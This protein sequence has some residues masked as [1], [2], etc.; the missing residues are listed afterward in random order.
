M[1]IFKFS[2]M[3]ECIYCWEQLKSN[4]SL[5]VGPCQPN[6]PVDVT[7][8][9]GWTMG[10]GSFLYFLPFTGHTQLISHYIVKLH[11]QV[12]IQIQRFYPSLHIHCLHHIILS[13][14]RSRSREHGRIIFILFTFHFFHSLHNIILSSSRSN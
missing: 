12:Q 8:A 14:S 2:I 6:N 1:I 7:S 3:C 5:L 11:V 9:D 4:F 13:S 10:P